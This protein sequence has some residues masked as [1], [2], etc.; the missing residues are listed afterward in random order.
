MNIQTLTTIALMA[1]CVFTANAALAGD[2]TIEVS[3]PS[4]K[5]GTVMAA[6]FDKAEG[7]PRGTALRTARAQSIN[8]KTTLLFTDLPKGD[9]AVTAFLDENSNT[10]LD[11]NLLGIPTEPYGFSRNARGLMGPPTFAD[12]A[13]R[14]EDS[15]QLQAFDL[16]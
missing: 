13:V 6:I 5:Q 11:T 15:A 16:K 14:V 7:F 9:Y 4:G 8:G 12:A 10:K 3:V 1:S 2:L